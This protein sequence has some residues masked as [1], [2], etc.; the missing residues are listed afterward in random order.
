MNK[1]GDQFLEMFKES[2][3]DYSPEVPSAVYAGVRKKMFWSNFMGFNMAQLNIWYVLLASSSVALLGW[4]NLEQESIGSVANA[5]EYQII[6]LR[7]PMM[8]SV[9]HMPADEVDNTAIQFS[10]KR[11]T[12]TREPLVEIGSK[13]VCGLVAG[14]TKPAT[15][16]GT[17]EAVNRGEPSAKIDNHVVATKTVVQEE[18]VQEKLNTEADV[19]TIIPM[20]MGGSLVED[21][22]LVDQLKEKDGPIELNIHVKKTSSKQ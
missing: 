1:H 18:I 5:S 17:E 15:K 11:S 12:S 16:V 21:S 22:N 3:G 8:A 6:E 13:V 4:S 9:V 19:R 2:F 10:P 20:D 14:N 7:E